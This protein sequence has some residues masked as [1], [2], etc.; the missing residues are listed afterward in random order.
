[1]AM[2]TLLV[3]GMLASQEREMSPV[4]YSTFKIKRMGLCKMK[5]RAKETTYEDFRTVG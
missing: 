3:S 1:M 5:G 4:K 2:S